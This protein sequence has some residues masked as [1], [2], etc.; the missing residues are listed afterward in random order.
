METPDRIVRSVEI[1]AAPDRVWRALTDHA[2][3]GTWFRVNLEG[4]FVVGEF[5]TGRITYPG[6]EHLMMEVLVRTIE[7]M[8]RFAFEWR[9]YAIDP[10]HDYSK[11]PRTLVEFHVEK[12]SGG[13]RVTVTES[14]F[15]RIPA[16]RRDEAFR[17]NDGGWAEQVK[18]IRAHVEA[19]AN[20]TKP[21]DC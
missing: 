15:S 3:F 12:V 7:P 5:A 18:N 14:G 21:A 9:P 16:L 13:V 4:P 20:T 11:E 1:N 2:E 10:A 6:Y 8:R 17:M 19:N